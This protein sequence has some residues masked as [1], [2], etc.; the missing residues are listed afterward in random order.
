MIRKFAL[1]NGMFSTKISL[2]KVIWLKTAAAHPGS[3]Q[4]KKMS[5]TCLQSLPRVVNT[6]SL[7]HI[8]HAWLDFF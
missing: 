2:A 8:Y 6:V 1:A 7:Q 4:K 3:R 5:S